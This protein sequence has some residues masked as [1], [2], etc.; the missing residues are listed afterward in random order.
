MWSLK[1]FK[2]PKSKCPKCSF[3]NEG[4]TTYYFIGPHILGYGKCYNCEI[5]YHHN[6]P[7]G[8]GADFP[9]A[10]SENGVAQYSEKSYQWM[11]KPLVKAVKTELQLDV[12]IKQIVR[13]DIKHALLLNCLDTCYG[14]VIW[15]LFNTTFYQNIPR[16]QGVIV[17]IPENCKWMVPDHV[18]EIWTVDLSLEFFN[19]QLKDLN[20][21]I[22]RQ[23][24]AY[25]KFHILPVFTHIDHQIVD[26]YQFFRTSPFQLEEF[27]SKQTQITFIWREDRVWL[28]TKLEAW[29]NLVVSRLALNWL[30]PLLLYRQL[31][32]MKK[33]GKAVKKALPEVGFKVTG[34]G[35]WGKFPPEYEDLRT[36]KTTEELEIK[37]CDTYADSHL[38]IGIHGSNMLIPTALASGFIEM[39][40]R[41]KIPFVSEDILMQHPARYQT[42]LG[43]HL[44]MS[45]SVQDISGHIISMVIDFPYLY[46]NTGAKI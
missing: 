38:V 44:S 3:E 7:I 35:T 18:A 5:F 46:K 15:K 45:T 32:I 8:H 12:P 2:S 33:V 20:S 6:W 26:S 43:R 42:F 36:L 17:M 27:S 23:L 14:H 30:K 39:L 34:L 22:D 21:F 28:P 29:A 16:H 37:W 19:F 1:P 11:V 10:F 24:D 4:F 25:D 40:P 41:H 31:R 9:I 13:R